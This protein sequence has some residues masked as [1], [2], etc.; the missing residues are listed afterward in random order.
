METVQMEGLAVAHVRRS[1]GQPRPATLPCSVRSVLQA[2]SPPD[3]ILDMAT[4]R[5]E[6]L[7]PATE[8]P[9]GKTRGWWKSGNGWPVW[10]CTRCLQTLPTAYGGWA[11]EI[12][13][14]SCRY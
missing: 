6:P 14:Q 12:H 1:G 7:D 4:G 10:Q 2:P 5:L 11:V 3:F 13:L 9:D 8:G